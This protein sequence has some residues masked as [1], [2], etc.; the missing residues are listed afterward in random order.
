[1]ASDSSKLNDVQ[2]V[3]FYNAGNSTKSLRLNFSSAEQWADAFQLN[4]ITVYGKV[5]SQYILC[6]YV[7][8]SA[9]LFDAA[10]S[11]YDPK[12]C[13]G[14]QPIFG[15]MYRRFVRT[16]LDD[17]LW[18]AHLPFII[19][20]RAICLSPFYILVLAFGSLICCY[21]IA[22]IVEWILSSV[23]FFFLT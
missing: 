4:E 1:L 17:E 21:L 18:T 12:F 6:P 5:A 10:D 7:I 23:D 14:V 11:A 19:A 22:F 16:W 13:P 20:I 3:Y 9:V 8:Y 15:V 2:S